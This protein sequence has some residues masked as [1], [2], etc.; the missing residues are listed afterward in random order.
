MET[1]ERRGRSI[2]RLERGRL[3][4]RIPDRTPVR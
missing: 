4:A 2:T 1:D 3:D